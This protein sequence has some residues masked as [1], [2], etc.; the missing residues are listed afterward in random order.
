MITEKMIF[1]NFRSSCHAQDY[2]QSAQIIV[3]EATIYKTPQ[4]E[5]YQYGKS[6]LTCTQTWKRAI[7]FEC[8][9]NSDSIRMKDKIKE[10]NVLADHLLQKI[11]KTLPD[12][13]NFAK[14]VTEG[15]VCDCSL[16]Y[17]FGF[18]ITWGNEYDIEAVDVAFSRFDE[19]IFNEANELPD[20]VLEFKPYKG[21]LPVFCTVSPTTRTYI[22]LTGKDKGSIIECYEDE[23]FKIVTDSFGSYVDELFSRFLWQIKNDEVDLL[24]LASTKI[25]SIQRI[26]NQRDS[27]S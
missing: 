20:D 18:P 16:R 14:F 25:L 10:K 1:S 8:F 26:E 5:L 13:Y 23:R 4:N 27:W 2:T 17:E 24:P 15:F 19:N 6:V 12:F 21:V 3:N 11:K 9:K 22:I 7:V